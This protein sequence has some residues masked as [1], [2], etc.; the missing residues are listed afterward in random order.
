M[1]A[2]TSIDAVEWLRKQVESAPDP[3]KELLTE[4]LGM[5]M[6]AEAE[7]LCGASYGE[8]NAS[9]VNSRNGYRQRQ[10]DSRMGTMTLS[11]PKLR[12]GTYFPSWLRRR[13]GAG[14]SR[15]CGPGPARSL[16][17]AAPRRRSGRSIL[18]DRR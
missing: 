7:A 6:N 2:E 16:R 13:A 8:R 11:I 14:S 4:M 5:L 15:R 3:V 1:A 9:R 10:W 12:Q 18:I 17:R